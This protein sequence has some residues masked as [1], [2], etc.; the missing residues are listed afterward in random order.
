MPNCDQEGRMQKP[1]R[2]KSTADYVT[3]EIQRR[4]LSGDLRPGARLDQIDL[5]GQLDV[6]RHPI[7]QA[8]DRLAER[9]FVKAAPHHSAVV[10]ELS[11][12]DLE[13]LYDARSVLESWA[14]REVVRRPDDGF[15]AR[16]AALHKALSAIDPKQDLDEYM[17]IN[18]AFHLAMYEP[19][20][21]R[22]VLRMIAVLFDL[23]E[24]Y[25]RTA[26]G[27]SA[28]IERSRREH[29]AMARAARSRDWD[30]LVALIQAHNEGTRATVRAFVASPGI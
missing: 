1:V 28:R 13:E 10:A 15:Q 6:S 18:R 30:R 2:H 25:Q 9:G 5:A 8:I 17:Q 16:V 24:R 4:I 14:I 27:E 11:V 21:N 7:R 22:H 20:A 23:S 26:L 3:A 12:Q 29:A 19:C